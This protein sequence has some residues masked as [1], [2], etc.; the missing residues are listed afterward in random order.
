MFSPNV[1]KASHHS[2]DRCWSY[3]HYSYQLN[4]FFDFTQFRVIIC[5]HTYISVFV[6]NIYL[7]ALHC[8]HA[9]CVHWQW[10]HSTIRIL[11]GGLVPHQHH[12]WGSFANAPVARHNQLGWLAF[13]IAHQ[14]RYSS[15]A[16]CVA[17]AGVPFVLLWLH[18]SLRR[19]NSRR[20]RC[21]W[22]VAHSRLVMYWGRTPG[23]FLNW[24]LAFSNKSAEAWISS[25]ETWHSVSWLIDVAMRWIAA[26]SIGPLPVHETKVLKA[27]RE[28][29]GIVSG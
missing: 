29:L 12:L 15:L 22:R 27:K 13:R 14:K 5:D 8:A 18:C 16:A 9:S 17:G 25:M 23:T 3:L 10:R 7:L 1:E 11:S 24:R 2:A 26:S 6:L 20:S 19:Y 28:I 4:V 21:K